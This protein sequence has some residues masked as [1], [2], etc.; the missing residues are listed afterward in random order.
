M[1]ILTY[2]LKLQGRDDSNGPSIQLFRP[3]WSSSFVVDKPVASLLF[4]IPPPNVHLGSSLLLLIAGLLC[5]F[6]CVFYKLALLS[7]GSADGDSWSRYFE[8][9]FLVVDGLYD[10]Q[11]EGYEDC[12]MSVHT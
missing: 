3:S 1:R 8:G 5:R 12:V 10:A 7:G 2:Q 9:P 6:A 4:G 11:G